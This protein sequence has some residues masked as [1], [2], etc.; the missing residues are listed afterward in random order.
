[1]TSNKWHPLMI[2]HCCLWM[3]DIKWTTTTFQKIKCFVDE[4]P[5]Y[6]PNHLTGDDY[7]Y[8]DHHQEDQDDQECPPKYKDVLYGFICNKYPFI[9]Q[10]W[11]LQLSW[12]PS[13]RSG[14]PEMSPKYKGVLDGFMCKRYPYILC[15]WKPRNKSSW[16]LVIPDVMITI[17]KIRNVSNVLQV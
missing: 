9:I 4:P 6:P 17:R 2:S 8:H 16:M 15:F 10:F 7:S 14:W 11:K 13:R 3:M 1:M 5:S 12:S